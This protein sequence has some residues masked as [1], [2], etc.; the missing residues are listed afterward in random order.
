M[1][2]ASM[3]ASVTCTSTGSSRTWQLGWGQG[4]QALGLHRAQ[5]DSG[6]AKGWSQA[7][8]PAREAPASRAT[9]TQQGIVASPAPATQAGRGHF[10]TSKSTTPVMATSECLLCHYVYVLVSTVLNQQ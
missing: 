1:A 8:S 7:A 2:P 6:W 3:A 4:Q 9:A 10:V 5:P